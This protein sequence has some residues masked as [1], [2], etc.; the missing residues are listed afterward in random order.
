M[1]D[2]QGQDELE[3]LLGR[4]AAP[5]GV[6]IPSLAILYF[7][8]GWCKA[9]K[10]LDMTAIEAA[11]P[12]ATWLTCNVDTQSYPAGFCGV[13]SIPAFMVIQGHKAVGP[14]VSSD[15]AKVMEW[16]QGV[17]VV[18]ATPITTGQKSKDLKE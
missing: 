9:C 11:W 8:A 7:T 5:V 2:L 12:T 6:E 1:R 15:T 18:P 4:Q 16:L 17:A 10:R 14:F 13:R 3:Q